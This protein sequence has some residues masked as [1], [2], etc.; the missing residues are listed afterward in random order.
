[1]E[2]QLHDFFF[3]QIPHL[4]ISRAST[5]NTIVQVL[6]TYITS[7]NI[8]YLEMSLSGYLEKKS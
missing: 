6:R 5:S 1:M 4:D 3:L 7:F 2:R 8:G